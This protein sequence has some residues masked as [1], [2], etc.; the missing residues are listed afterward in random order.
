MELLFNELSIHPL[1]VDKYAANTKMIYFSEAVASARKNGFR[2]IRSHYD[3]HQIELATDYSLYNWLNS[4]DVYEIHRNNLYGMIILPF[5]SED[6]E[7]IETRFVEANYFF[8][9]V[10]NGI[11]K[12]E[13]LGL[14]SAFLY[15]TLSVSL[16]SNNAWNRNRLEL[17]IESIDITQIEVVF[18]VFSKGCFGI[19]VISDFIEQLG[20][21]VLMKTPIAPDS[22]N[23]HL[24]DHHGQKE[25]KVLWAKLKNSPYV[26]E[27]RST[28]WGG[29]RFIR[30]VERNG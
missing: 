18:N 28:N 25:L 29:K 13:C 24:A 5:I 14:A 7:A 9:D 15:E 4:K 21:V 12:T 16:Q 11:S 27:G 6:D 10:A 17:L 3:S 19:K 30:K 2:N 20:T 26:I 1:S 23:I 22:K 8:E